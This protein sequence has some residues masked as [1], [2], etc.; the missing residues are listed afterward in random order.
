M[1]CIRSAMISLA[2]LDSL[3]LHNCARYRLG[4]RQVQAWIE[5]GRPR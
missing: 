5:A 2:E 3:A 4:M 1:S